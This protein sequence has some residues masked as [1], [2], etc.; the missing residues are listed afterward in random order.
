M[1]EYTSFLSA[2]GCSISPEDDDYRRK[3]FE[4]AQ[5]FRTFDAALDE[6]IV[7]KG[8]SDDIT[9]IN[10]KVK[11]IQ[12]KFER[13]GIAIET[14]ILSGWFKNHTQADKREIAIKFCFAFQLTLEETQ[15]FFRRIYLQRNL[16]CHNVQEAIYY[17]C[18]SNHLTYSEAQALIAQAPVQN[19]KGGISKEK[20]VL[21]TGTIIKELDR[22]QNPEELLLFLDENR[23]QFGYNN[24]TAKKYINELWRRISEN[25]GLAYQE[26]CRRYPDRKVLDKQR[27]VWNIYRQIFGL[28][29][30]D[31]VDGTKLF[32]TKGDRTIQPLLKANSL[33]HPLARK[34]FPD[35][36]GLEAIIQGNWQSDEVVR[37]TIILLSFYRFWTE[38][39]L[40]DSAPEYA[41]RPDDVR[42]CIA[43]MNRFLVDA[44]YPELYEGNPYDWIFIFAVQDEYPLEAFRFFMREVYLNKEE[45]C[46]EQQ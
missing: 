27:S 8:Y 17:Y 3:L 12:E 25:G 7:Q 1:G 34:A 6:F 4:V 30:Y 43:S 16:D 5:A 9:D 44:G 20:D 13:A 36:Q 2:R 38:L 33:I 22:F 10:S 11:F 24:A 40:K 41:A 32:S 21:Y 28:L 26:M 31:S 39:F 46:G 37:K 23:E 45:S 14:R 42:R 35:R 15:D 18:I 29:D 19:G